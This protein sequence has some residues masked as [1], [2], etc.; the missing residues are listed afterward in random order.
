MSICSCHTQDADNFVC[1]A[2][3]TF[4]LM[5]TVFSACEGALTL[6]ERRCSLLPFVIV[7][8]VL[9]VEDRK[10]VRLATRGEWLGFL[11]RWVGRSWPTFEPVS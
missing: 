9:L 11:R 1:E 10:M 5:M 6:Q 8:A 3:R 7:M 4:R 2:L